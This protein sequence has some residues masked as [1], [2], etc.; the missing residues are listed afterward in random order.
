MK[1]LKPGTCQIRGHE[2]GCYNI[3]GVIEACFD[4]VEQIIQR[5]EGKWPVHVMD[6]EE[7]TAAYLPESEDGNSETAEE[8]VERLACML[9]VYG[10]FSALAEALQV[11]QGAMNALQQALA[12]MGIFVTFNDDAPEGASVI[13]D[14]QPKK[15]VH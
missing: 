11:E 9:S 13:Q 7:L 6:N 14:N 12:Q 3:R 4:S 5:H 1:Y 10:Q 2:D 15:M 8:L